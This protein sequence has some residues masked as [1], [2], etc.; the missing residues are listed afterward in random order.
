M[1]PNTIHERINAQINQGERMAQLLDMGE[2]ET[3]KFARALELLCDCLKED[4]WWVLD[5]AYVKEDTVHKIFQLF[6]K[7]K[8]GR[9]HLR[10]VERVFDNI[11]E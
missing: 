6:D 9:F 11:P 8:T 5:S 1:A 7:K 3:P 10:D 4:V 2:A